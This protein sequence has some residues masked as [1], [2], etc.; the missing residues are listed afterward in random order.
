MFDSKPNILLVDDEDALRGVVAERLQD[1]GY[2]VVEAGSG[3][4]ALEQLQ[5]FAFD[6][7]IS[8]LRLPGIDGHQVLDAA[9]ER[10]QQELQRPVVAAPP[11]R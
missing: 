1:E 8:D 10:L 5:R 7:V 3:E 2:T 6:I 4:A 9:L 11:G